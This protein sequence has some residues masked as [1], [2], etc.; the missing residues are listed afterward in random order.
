MKKIFLSVF[1]M[2]SLISEQTFAQENLRTKSNE[3]QYH[4]F[5]NNIPSDFNYP[6]IV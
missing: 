6:L 1:L 3:V 5:T 2:L 4:F